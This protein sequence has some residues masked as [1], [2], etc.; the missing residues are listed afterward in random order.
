MR[1]FCGPSSAQ[2]VGPRPA[3]DPPMAAAMSVSYNPPPA[4]AT[5]T[6]CAS[7]PPA[8]HVDTQLRKKMRA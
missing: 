7:A 4:R 3:G 6:G 5:T 2:N 8:A 1:L